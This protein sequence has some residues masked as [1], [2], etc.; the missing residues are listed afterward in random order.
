MARTGRLQRSNEFSVGPAAL[1]LA[2]GKV[3]EQSLYAPTDFSALRSDKIAC[4]RPSALCASALFIRKEDLRLPVDRGRIDSE[5]NGELF[6]A[7]HVMVDPIPFRD[8]HVVN[9]WLAVVA[10]TDSELRSPR[11]HEKRGR[12]EDRWIV[13][14]AVYHHRVALASQLPHDFAVAPE[15]FSVERQHLPYM[16]IPR[17]HGRGSRCRQHIH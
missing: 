6:R 3:D 17:Q 1:R 11:V 14:P 5:W 9:A 7:F 13:N 8:A 10:R 12:R 4:F 16:W 2:R 15:R